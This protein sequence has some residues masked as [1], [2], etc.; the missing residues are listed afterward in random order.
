MNQRS[1]SLEGNLSNLQDGS[2][3]FRVLAVVL[4]VIG[5]VVLGAG[6]LK[7]LRLL[8]GI[9]GAVIADAVQTASGCLIYFLLAWFA[10]RTSEAFD[11]IAALIG[12]MGEIV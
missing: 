12:E 1:S 10:R 6:G 7:L 3:A 11:A 2:R 5:F 4:T 9:E 8:R